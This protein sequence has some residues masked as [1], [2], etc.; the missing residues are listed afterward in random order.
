M[1]T[2]NT[3]NKRTHRESEIQRACVTWFKY[4]HPTKLLFAIP[5][6]GARNKVEASIMA[7]EGVTAG[8]ADLQLLF[9]NGQYF[10]LF[11]EMKAGKNGQTDK[12]KEFQAYCDRNK[13][14]Y[15]VCRSVDEF[16]HEVNQYLS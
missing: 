10:S 5:N 9:G 15:V 1:I 11:I 12:Q 6:G 7:G 14:K 4:Q 13:F 2:Q 16:I 3:A 8:V